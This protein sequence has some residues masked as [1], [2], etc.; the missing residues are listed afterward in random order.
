M[1]L[2]ARLRR[3]EQVLRPRTPRVVICCACGKPRGD[4]PEPPPDFNGQVIR[5]IYAHLPCPHATPG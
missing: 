5:I 2:K 4:S 3:I 1:A